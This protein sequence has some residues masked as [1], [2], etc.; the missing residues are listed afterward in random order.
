MKPK[1]HNFYTVFVML[2]QVCKT[3]VVSTI[4]ESLNELMM[5]SDSY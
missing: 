5:Q 1:S 3:N 2:M 4:N